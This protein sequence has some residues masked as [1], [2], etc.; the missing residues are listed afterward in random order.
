MPT[1]NTAI[2]SRAADM[3]R[4]GRA[5]PRRG[6]HH[7][8]KLGNVAGGHPGAHALAP[9]LDAGRIFVL[10]IIEEFGFG[11]RTGFQALSADK[12]LGHKPPL[13]L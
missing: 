7:V 9:D 10:Q 1:K 2:Q 13:R 12:P 4:R 6:R 3:R 8:D 11:K 5:A